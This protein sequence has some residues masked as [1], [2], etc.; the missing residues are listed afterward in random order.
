MVQEQVKANR[1]DHS[2]IV[3]RCT[4]VHKTLLYILIDYAFISHLISELNKLS[5]PLC[6]LIDKL[7]V[8]LLCV[9]PQKLLTL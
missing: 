5:S 3:T 4:T 9:P 2:Q 7:K 6:A 8:I 1:Y